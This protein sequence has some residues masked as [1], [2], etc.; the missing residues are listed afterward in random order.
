MG[1]LKRWKKPSS[2]PSPATLSS[3]CLKKGVRGE[4]W[5]SLL[6]GQAGKQVLDQC[7]PKLMRQ[8]AVA[9]RSYSAVLWGKQIPHGLAWV[10]AWGVISTCSSQRSSHVD[11][12]PQPFPSYASVSPCVFPTL[13]FPVIEGG[14]DGGEK[15]KA[16]LSGL[17]CTGDAYAL[18]APSSRAQAELSMGS[19]PRKS[20][21]QS[22][23]LAA[24]LPG[25]LFQGTMTEAGQ[26]FLPWHISGF[27]LPG[28]KEHPLLET[29][30]SFPP[31]KAFTWSLGEKLGFRATQTPPAESAPSFI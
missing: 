30:P 5:C 6:S 23:S 1:V 21:P 4:G 15:Q 14:K 26:F 24:A 2:H 9:G 11:S 19:G 10:P 7:D 13:P 12:H 31:G 8:A 18:G 25:S 22:V 3:T 27:V 16:S 28:G 17:F 20:S 29:L